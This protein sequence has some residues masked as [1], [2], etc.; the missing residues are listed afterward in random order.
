MRV[1]GYVLLALAIQVGVSVFMG[2]F[3]A[4]GRGQ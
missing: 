4:A 2:R 3:I 1:A